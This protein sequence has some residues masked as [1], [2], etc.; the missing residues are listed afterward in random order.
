VTQWK[1]TTA[2]YADPEQAGELRRPI[3]ED[4]GPIPSP[5]GS[6]DDAQAG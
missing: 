1:A 5:G 6:D 4:L 2:I 3:T